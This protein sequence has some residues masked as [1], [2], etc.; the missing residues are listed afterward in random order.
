LSPQTQTFCNSYRSR[1]LAR[2][3]A[4]GP[5]LLIVLIVYDKVKKTDFF[6]LG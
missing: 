6:A 5:P 3:I 4:V 1:E 2:S